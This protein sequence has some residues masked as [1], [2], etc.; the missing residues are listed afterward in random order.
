M[1]VSRYIE[2]LSPQQRAR[3]VAGAVT[4]VLCVAIG[5]FVG[6]MH[7]TYIP[8]GQQT[9]PPAD[10]SELLLADEY[11][12]AGDVE[13]P[14][15]TGD[16]PS[17]EADVAEP[18]TE[19]HDMQNEGAQAQTPAPPIV[20]ERTSPMKVPAPKP[21]EEKTGP[22]KAEI[23]AQKAREK[24]ESETRQQI[25]GKV[26]F[27]SNN[28]TGSGKSGATDGN[29]ATGSL[30]GAPGYSLSGRTLAHWELPART[31][32]N[33]VVTVRVV[34]NQQGQVVEAS[35]SG[36]SGAAA[37]ESVRSACVAAARKSKFSVKLDAPSRQSGTITYKFV[38][39]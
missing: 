29:S 39:K 30:S 34:V 24:A 6:Y 25:A 16:E 10:S 2:S 5:L 35:V 31:A 14:E 15:Q 20:S 11:V 3:I 8:A 19:G 4:L 36:S 32:P 27:G 37:T 28:S 12:V 21:A 13:L 7:L 38:A 26:K 23:E 33:G 18:T 22:T 17:A 1:N 9:W